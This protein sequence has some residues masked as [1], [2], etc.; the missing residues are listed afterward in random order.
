MH[1]RDDEQ[2]LVHQ[3]DRKRQR[4]HVAAARRRSINHVL[5]RA[6]SMCQVVEV[7]AALSSGFTLQGSKASRSAAVVAK[8]SRS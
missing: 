8:G 7:A 4:N 6:E 5:A 1:V 3:V 2:R